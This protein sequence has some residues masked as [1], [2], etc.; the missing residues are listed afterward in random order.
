MLIKK[1]DFEISIGKGVGHVLEDLI[2]SSKER[3]WIVSPWISKKY[4]E[5]IKEK[6]NK[7]VDVKLLTS[8]DFSNNSHKRAVSDLVDFRRKLRKFP[9]YAS[10]LLSLIL[11]SLS[12]FDIIWLAFIPL[13]VFVFFFYGICFEAKPK[14]D[15]YIFDRKKEFTHSKIYI[16]DNVSAVGSANLTENGLWRNIET[17]VIIKDKEITEEIRSIFNNIKENPFLKRIELESLR[18]VLK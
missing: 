16:L 3:I 11:L 12:A 4:S 8:N 9:A 17:I 1:G 7:G 10:F 5:I 13:P 6:A 15:L 14:I 2:F 18:K